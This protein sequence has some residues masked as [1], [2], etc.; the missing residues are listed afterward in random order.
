MKQKMFDARD[1]F[2]GLK[3][4]SEDNYVMFR[5]AMADN[6]LKLVKEHK[7]NCNSECDIQLFFLSDVYKE[8][9]GCKLTKN[10]LKE[11]L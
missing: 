8:L 10:E 3:I 2:T 6:L 7:K 9:K 5:K 4:L 1:K 11:F